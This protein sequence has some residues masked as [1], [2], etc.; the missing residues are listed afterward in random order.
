MPSTFG[1]PPHPRAATS[2]AGGQELA[3]FVTSHYI[4]G[5]EPRPHQAPD[6]QRCATSS[7]GL[8]NWVIQLQELTL[9]L[10]K[11][12]GE[13]F[14]VHVYSP[15]AP[16]LK[17]LQRVSTEQTPLVLHRA[18]AGQRVCA[19]LSQ[20]SCVDLQHVCR[21]GRCAGQRDAEA[22]GATH[23]QDAAQVGDRLDGPRAGRRLPRHG[24]APSRRMRAPS[25][26]CQASGP[27]CLTPACLPQDIEVLPDLAL[28]G[29]ADV[30]AQVERVASDWLRLLRCASASPRRLH[31]FPDFSSP[32]NAAIMLV[33]P[34][35]ALYRAGLDVLRGAAR[36]PFD[37]KRGWEG[38]GPPLTVTPKG[39]DA[40]RRRRG[41]MQMLDLNTHDFVGASID[42]GFFHHMMR[43]RAALGGAPSIPCDARRGRDNR[44]V[45][46]FRARAWSHLISRRVLVSPVAGDIRL[47][48]C[49]HPPASPPAPLA[50][51]SAAMGRAPLP[52]APQ[53]SY[54]YHYGAEGPSPAWPALA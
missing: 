34:E 26:S 37:R 5:Y 51:L 48:P 8:A 35:L 3:A 15:C 2:F 25:A 36:R 31:S 40:W 17:D 16:L 44:R 41:H 52:A 13:H 39:D 42:Q 43:V 11:R 6:L 29:F 50:A 1:A 30:G 10:H 38:L 20:H 49:F 19:Y 7:C 46:C 9:R 22:D 54:Y 28:Q 45:P 18:H 4:T 33:R 14:S 47:M 12:S 23:A 53:E 32:V 24:E 21:G 27:A